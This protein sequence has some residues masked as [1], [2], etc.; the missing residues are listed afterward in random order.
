VKY[1]LSYQKEYSLKI[2]KKQKSDKVEETIKN[3]VI[4]K[5]ENDKLNSCIKE[6]QTKL[7]SQHSKY[8]LLTSSH[9]ELQEDKAKNLQKIAQLDQHRETAEFLQKQ[10]SHIEDKHLKLQETHSDTIEQSE[11]RIRELEQLVQTYRNDYSQ[12]QGKFQD[13][14]AQMLDLEGHTLNDLKSENHIY[15][16]ENAFMK[17][18]LQQ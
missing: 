17:D 10:L 7:D 1:T 11:I 3:N 14:N 9:K 4:L 2:E 18:Q 8:E 5:H 15:K 6:M 13:L 16:E 12:I